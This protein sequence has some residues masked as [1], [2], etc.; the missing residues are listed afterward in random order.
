MLGIVRIKIYLYLELFERLYDTVKERGIE[1][2]SK[3]GTKK[4]KM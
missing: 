1:R 2:K 3:Q 4:G